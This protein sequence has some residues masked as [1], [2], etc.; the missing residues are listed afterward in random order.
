VGSDPRR[1]G[2][3]GGKRICADEA[4]VNPRSFVLDMTCAGQTKERM[5]ES[6]CTASD[7]LEG[8]QEVRKLFV[9]YVLRY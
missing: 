1:H 9:I 8:R 3:G 4:K 7:G 5:R 6:G 2:R